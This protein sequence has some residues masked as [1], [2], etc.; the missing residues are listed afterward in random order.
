MLVEL[1]SK[2]PVVFETPSFPV[3]RGEGIVFEHEIR[4][5]DD[6]AD[7]PRKRLYPLD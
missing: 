1:Q 3:Q 7:P 4:L 2:Y 6:K 5:K